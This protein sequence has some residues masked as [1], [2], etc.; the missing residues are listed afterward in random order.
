MLS[1]MINNLQIDPRFPGYISSGW[2]AKQSLAGWWTVSCSL[3]ELGFGRWAASSGLPTPMG[4]LPCS[5]MGWMWV[6]YHRLLV[7]GEPAECLSLA[8][9][10]KGCVVSM[11]VAGTIVLKEIFLEIFDDAILSLLCPGCLLSNRNHLGQGQACS[12]G[13]CQEIVPT[14]AFAGF[15]WWGWKHHICFCTLL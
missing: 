8:N 11:E 4:S 2:L 6:R 5:H 14:L 12:Y 9:C 13:A 1:C 7:R 10:E 15:P 3:W